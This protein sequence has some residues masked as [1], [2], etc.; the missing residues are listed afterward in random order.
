M[1]GLTPNK[2]LAL[3]AGSILLA[4]QLSK[5]AVLRFLPEGQEVSV[6][7]GFFKL[8][9]WVNTGAAWSSFSGN[10]HWLALVGVVALVVLF[11]SRHHFEAH[12]VP[13]QMALGLV[14]GGIVGNLID[15]VVRQHV[16]DFLVFYV[17]QR[18]GGEAVFP[19]FN[20]A[21]S[22]ICTGVGLIFLGTWRNEQA[23]AAAAAPQRSP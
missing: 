13:G 10:N 19:A 4:D 11:F 23:R 21:D 3:V 16:I 1:A 7:D 17:Q 20:V 15:R 18:G 9:H 12:T 6:L 5:L 22:A 2:R 14:F 8:V